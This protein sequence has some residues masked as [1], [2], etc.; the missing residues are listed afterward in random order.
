VVLTYPAASALAPFRTLANHTAPRNRSIQSTRIAIMPR[1]RIVTV[2]GGGPAGMSCALWLANYGLRTIIIERESTL[3]GMARLSP[4]PNDW[5][6]GRP[7]ESGRE[8]AAAFAR[9]IQQTPVECLLGARP[10]RLRSEADHSFTLALTRA[11]TAEAEQIP[12]DAVVIATGTRFR[13]EEW[14]FRIDNA[15]RLADLG[16]VHL[17]PSFVGEHN[18]DLGSHVAVLGGG[19]NAFDVSRMLVESGVRV[20]LLMR[21]ARARARPLLVDALRRH[22]ISGMARIRAQCEVAAL[23]D[24]GSRVA[25]RLDGGEELEVDHLVLLFGYQPNSDAFWLAELALERDAN[26]YLAVDHNMETRCGG[27]FAIGDIATPAHPCVATA[28]AT[29]TMAARTIER[30]LSAP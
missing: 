10:Q 8:N 7:A 4:Y 9:H 26:G 14:L 17:G 12:S 1:G 3:G 5:L 2:I 15:R 28:I 24:S 18:F 22:T 6:L 29:G 30:R 19:D 23:A 16:R 13:G 25:V 21:S 11:G 20:T 27:L